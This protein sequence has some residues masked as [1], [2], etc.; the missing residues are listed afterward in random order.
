MLLYGPFE[1]IFVIIDTTVHSLVHSLCWKSAC[2]TLFA[3]ALFIF[4]SSAVCKIWVNCMRL[5]QQHLSSVNFLVYNHAEVNLWK[6]V[7][8]L[9][10]AYRFLPCSSHLAFTITSST[11]HQIRYHD[12]NH[13]RNCVILANTPYF[14]KLKDCSSG[15][16]L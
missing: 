8:R 12:Y 5:T 1:S 16:S 9:L 2:P 7:P 4:C 11:E 10:K 14:Y 3:A 15:E 13:F 6:I